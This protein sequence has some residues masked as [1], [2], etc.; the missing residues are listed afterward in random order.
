[1]VLIRKTYIVHANANKING[2]PSTFSHRTDWRI[3]YLFIVII[4]TK[5][6]ERWTKHFVRLGKHFCVDC[7]A[8]RLSKIKSSNVKQM[9]I[10]LLVRLPVHGRKDKFLLNE[11]LILWGSESTLSFHVPRLRLHSTVL[12]RSR[13]VEVQLLR[14]KKKGRKSETKTRKRMMTCKQSWRLWCAKIHSK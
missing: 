5:C 14:I 1:M 11:K 2:F 7:V 6:R 12:Y 13:N 4:I 9:E 8:C 3:I 10:E